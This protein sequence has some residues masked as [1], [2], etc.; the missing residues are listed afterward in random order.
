MAMKKGSD[1]YRQ[2]FG[3]DVDEACIDMSKFVI[4]G[5]SFGGLTAVEVAS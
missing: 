2:I 5:H 4:A 3:E 1:F